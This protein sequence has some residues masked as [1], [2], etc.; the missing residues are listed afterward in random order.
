MFMVDIDMWHVVLQLCKTLLHLV[1]L[2]EIEDLPCLGGVL[3]SKEDTVK[4]Y[5]K[6]CSEPLGL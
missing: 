3:F 2:M 6:S 5:L 1:S 4:Q